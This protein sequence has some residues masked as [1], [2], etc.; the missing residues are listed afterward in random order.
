M[1]VECAALPQI[2]LIRLISGLK[3]SNG[4]SITREDKNESVV[5]MELHGHYAA[6]DLESPPFAIYY[7]KA[8]VVTP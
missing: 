4:L 1:D 2:N 7:P 6:E 8:P 3:Y 5:T